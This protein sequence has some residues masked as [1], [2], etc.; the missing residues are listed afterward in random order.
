MALGFLGAVSALS[1]SG[2][3]LLVVLEELAEKEKY[4]KFLE[5]LAGMS[6]SVIEPLR[7][8]KA[9]EN[10]WANETALREGIP[11]HIRI[12]KKRSSSII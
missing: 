1:S 6:N 2:S 12:A 3:R 5:D 4:S 7:A 10:D 8:F 9:L 11:N